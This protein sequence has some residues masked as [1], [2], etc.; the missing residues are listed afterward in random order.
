MIAGDPDGYEHLE[1]ELGDLWFQILF[2]AE[3]A[4]EAGAF[5]MADVAREGTLTD[6][7]GIGKILSLVILYEIQD[8]TRFPTVQDFKLAAEAAGMQLDA[9]RNIR[10]RCALDRLAR[11]ATFCQRQQEAYARPFFR[12]ARRIHRA[13]H[14]F[15]QTLDDGKPQSGSL[16]LCCK[17]GI[18]YFSSVCIQDWK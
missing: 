2:H 8:I 15:H 7:P 12:R 9:T 5:S 16:C 4:T 11:A 18:P 3:L 1:E 17:K 6:I 10:C 14:C 13:L